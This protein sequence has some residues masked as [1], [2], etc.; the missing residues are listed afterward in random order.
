M[1]YRDR[2]WRTG[3]CAESAVRARHDAL[4]PDEVRIALDPLGNQ[5]GVLDV[6]GRRVE[7]PRD[8]RDIVGQLRV[9]PHR[10]FVFVA[11]IRCLE[12]QRAGLGLLHHRHDPFQRNI[13]VVRSL[14][15]APADVNANLRGG[16]VGQSRVK[17]FDVGRRDP[18]R[19]GA[20]AARRRDRR[21]A[22]RAPPVSTIR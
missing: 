5:F 2:P 15:V 14:V 12:H 8:Q 16:D 1:R 6:V 22:E 3:K 10:P 18:Q 4:S 9:S 11:R 17:R 19:H 13:V 20:Q 7:H 21:E